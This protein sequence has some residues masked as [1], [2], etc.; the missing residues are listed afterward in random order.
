MIS[1]RWH[2][3]CDRTAER[4]S[5]TTQFQ[6]LHVSLNCWGGVVE[7]V[8]IFTDI[9]I[10]L[11]R[12]LASLLEPIWGRVPEPSNLISVF[13][14]MLTATGKASENEFNPKEMKFWHRG[15]HPWMRWDQSLAWGAG[16]KRKAWR[17]PKIRQHK[18]SS[19]VLLLQKRQGGAAGVWINVS[20]LQINSPGSRVVPVF[21]PCQPVLTM[22]SER[23]GDAAGRKML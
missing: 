19:F 17:R 8:H 9:V 20:S 23:R 12:G 2:W 13:P 11:V 21:L 15:H 14:L 6:G 22:G 3:P 5:T 10:T 18:W 7:V 4:A 1:F 16:R